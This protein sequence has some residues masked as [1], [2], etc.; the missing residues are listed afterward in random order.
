[1]ISGHRHL[2]RS[3]METMA[4]IML[5]LLV[6][7]AG[8]I[9]AAII[10]GI[11]DSMKKKRVRDEDYRRARAD[12]IIAENA[13]RQRL[14]SRATAPM[15]ME[16]IHKQW[17]AK[18][19]IGMPPNKKR[20]GKRV[21]RGNRQQYLAGSP[22]EESEHEFKEAI[23]MEETSEAEL[24]PRGG[25]PEFDPSMY[26]RRTERSPSGPR[27]VAV[28]VHQ[29]RSR[30]PMTEGSPDIPMTE[31]GPSTGQPAAGGGPADVLEKIPPTR[32][33]SPSVTSG[34]SSSGA[35]SEP[36]RR[37]SPSGGSAPVVSKEFRHRRQS[38]KYRRRSKSK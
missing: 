23:E 26:Q 13:R 37:R 10:L 9:L 14:K 25:R 38:V 24:H 20:F 15:K 29:E 8:G 2:F 1:M 6:I 31:A 32:R 30:S 19:V 34:S 12:S 16:S 17:S 22:I 33:R 11:R 3:I 27:E 28:D 7:I 5:I 36:G 18:K 21:L 4:L 35:S